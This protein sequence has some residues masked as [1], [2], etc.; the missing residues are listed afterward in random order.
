MHTIRK[1]KRS[2]TTVHKVESQESQ[3]AL[4]ELRIKEVIG[5]PNSGQRLET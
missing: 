4:E 5:I 2:V 1:A 3:L